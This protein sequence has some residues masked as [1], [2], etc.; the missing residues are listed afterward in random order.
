MDKLTFAG[1][2]LRAVFALALVL[3]T[4]NP[5]GY[6]YAHMLQAGFPAGHAARSG[7]RRRCC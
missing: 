1:F 3:L 5:S 4:F 6:S 2:L 7:A